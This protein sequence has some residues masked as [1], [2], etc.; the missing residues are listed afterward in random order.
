MPSSK[1]KTKTVY[2]GEI[3]F[4]GF[5]GYPFNLCMGNNNG[6]RNIV[7]TKMFNYV[8]KSLNAL[9]SGHGHNF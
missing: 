8:L 9:K 7:L 3:T 2:L 4:L 5:V 6:L 1:T